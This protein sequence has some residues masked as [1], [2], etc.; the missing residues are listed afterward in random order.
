MGKVDIHSVANYFRSCVDESA[1]ASITHLKL[2]KL[3]YYAQAWH[4]VFNGKPLFKEEFQAWVHGPACP[5]LWHVYKDFNWYGIPRSDCDPGIFSEEQIETLQAVWDAYGQYD[6]KYLEE[7]T[8][9]EQPWI[10][11]R[12]GYDPGDKCTN[13]I[14]H[15]SMVEY[16]ST[17]IGSNE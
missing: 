14:T 2:Q 6:G 7:L 3:C 11:A 1:G 5:D 8:H 10:N 12:R 17:L 4:L 15:N 9:Q 16:Y 13:I